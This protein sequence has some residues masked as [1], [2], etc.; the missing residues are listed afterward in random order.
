M[1]TP[2]TTEENMAIVRATL[3][4]RKHDEDQGI[5]VGESDDSKLN[6]IFMIFVAIDGNQN[7]RSM[8]Q[9]KDRFKEI[10]EEMEIVRGQSARVKAMSPEMPFFNRVSMCK[11]LLIKYVLHKILTLP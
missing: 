4:V 7:G 2:Y 1:V 6:R 10:Y 11:C 5:N 3:T 9:I 8:N